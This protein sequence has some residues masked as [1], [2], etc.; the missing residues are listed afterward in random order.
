MMAARRRNGSNADYP[1]ETVTRILKEVKE[2]PMSRRQ[3]APLDVALM[4]Y[5]AKQAKKAGIKERD[6]PRLIHE[7]RTRHRTP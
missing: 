1:M 3:G 4:A 7:S 6:I 5:G 2:R